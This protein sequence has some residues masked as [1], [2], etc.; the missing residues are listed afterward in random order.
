VISP[1]GP[2][3][4]GGQ[5]G[6][7]C[8]AWE[9]RLVPAIVWQPEWRRRDSKPCLLFRQGAFKL[10]SSLCILWIESHSYYC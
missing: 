4:G 6:T 8:D 9:P 10:E 2:G 5:L 1:D 3:S 7:D